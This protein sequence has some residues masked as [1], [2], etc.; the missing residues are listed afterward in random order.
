MHESVRQFTANG[1]ACVPLS[2]RQDG[3]RFSDTVKIAYLSGAPV[4]SRGANSVHVMRMCQAMA[5]QGHS[6]TLY[7][8]N[9]DLTARSDHEFYGV[10]PSFSILKHPRPKVRVIG[11]MSH[12]CLVGARFR[13][14]RSPDLVYAREYYCLSAVAK[15]GVPFIFESHW[16][17]R[18]R[19]QRLL[20]GWL[21]AQPGFRRLVVISQALR[22]GYLEVFRSLRPESVVVAHD[23]ADPVLALPN[24]DAGGHLRLQVGYVGSFFPGYGVQV[25]SD[26]ARLRPDMDFH[27]IGGSASDVRQA[28][29]CAGALA[30]LTFHGFVPPAELALKYRTLDVLL[31]PY[32]P[33][34]PHIDWISPMKLFEYMAH[35]KAIVCSDFPVM[36]EILKQGEDGLL[37]SATDVGSWVKALDALRD[38]KR[39]ATLGSA[40]QAKLEAQFTWRRRA[41]AV[42]QGI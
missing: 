2:L 38:P 42:L 6:V 29:A 16:R 9:G 1:A 20:E 19:G 39:R 25:L 37:V 34:T 32:Q 40:A 26:L 15:T 11:A 5:E 7:V 36:R 33:D 17:P 27:V 41:E 4:P 30:N 21:F 8:H 13:M 3:G 23:A 35:G 31:A 10:A 22:A 18:N 12:A 14:R 24:S 28:K